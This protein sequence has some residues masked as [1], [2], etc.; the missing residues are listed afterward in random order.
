MKKY[1]LAIIII[2]IYS[3]GMLNANSKYKAY[4]S[5]N[6]TSCNSCCV[7]AIEILSKELKENQNE[8]PIGYIEIILDNKAKNMKRLF[9]KNKLIDSINVLSSSDNL[10]LSSNRS[11]M[12]LIIKDSVDNVISIFT[13]FT[14]TITPT[15]TLKQYNDKEEF[16]IT[17]NEVS[18]GRILSPTIIGNSLYI[19]EPE[20]NLLWKYNINTKEIE[21]IPEATKE[22]K[23]TFYDPNKQNIEYWEMT[24][25]K[26]KSFIKYYSYFPDKDSVF[27][28]INIISGYTF[29]STM[30][31]VKW[32]SKFAIQKINSDEKII[33]IANL[34]NFFWLSSKSTRFYTLVNDSIVML[35]IITESNKVDFSFFN[36]NSKSILKL[37]IG[38]AD[39]KDLSV[40]SL[41]FTSDG[42]NNIIIY[43][44]HSS[45]YILYKYLGEDIKKVQD[46]ILI[47][48]T[49]N[50]QVYDIVA[51]DGKLYFL[52]YRPEIDSKLYVEEYILE[53][54]IQFSKSFLLNNNLD[55]LQSNIPIGIIDGNFYLLS[56]NEDYD[57][58]LEKFNLNRNRF[59]NNK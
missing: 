47:N 24:Y 11:P 33:S 37:S 29:D 51:S 7:T 39:L 53:N 15:N 36:T 19:I 58:K 57:W 26:Y 50:S 10:T 38:Q 23:F 49:V 31:E 18:V 22:I 5:I 44:Y 35:P 28:F 25:E 16:N 3:S 52:F 54:T 1:Y 48:H 27:A 20:S 9:A 34:P 55:Y 45:K 46:I 40:D 42:K 59:T 43:D 30:K 6:S 56:G 8:F 17:S 12:D 4:F 32:E 21:E 41:L 14:N 13:D 2:L